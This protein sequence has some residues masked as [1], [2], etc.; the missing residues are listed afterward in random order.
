[1]KK[2]LRILPFLS[3]VIEASAQAVVPV[4]IRATNTLEHLFDFN[5]IN[6]ADLLYGIPLPPGKVIGDT[7]IDTHWKNCS[8][9]LYD[10]DKLIEGYP[11]RYDIY[12]DELEIMGRNGIKVLKGNQVKSFVWADSITR[13]P[14]YFVDAKDYINEDNV[15]FT[16]FFQ[17]LSDGA[18]PLFKK[19]SIGI[20]KADYNV[21]LNVGSP[22]DKILKKVK[23]YT[24]DEKRVVELPV[25]R[26]KLFTLFDEDYEKIEQLVKDNNL[27]TSN[28]DHLVII[29]QHYNSQNN[30]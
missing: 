26:K 4:N 24:V 23:F 17:V 28:E 10:K 14:A 1:M 16:G 8:I 29:F 19:T 3:L 15:P 7:Y 5:G 20:K 30:H 18:M 2:L 13:V 27:S 22:D 9:L 6:N 25:S 12:M 21:Q 11:A